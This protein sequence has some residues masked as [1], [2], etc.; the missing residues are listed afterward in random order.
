V[1]RHGDGNYGDSRAGH[2]SGPSPT[3]GPDGPRRPAPS[4][5]GRGIIVHSQLLPGPSHSP[6][7]TSINLFPPSLGFVSATETERGQWQAG[8]AEPSS[9]SAT[10]PSPSAP[11]SSSSLF[12]WLCLLLV[13]LPHHSFISWISLVASASQVPSPFRPSSKQASKSGAVPSE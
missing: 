1:K 6:L 5:S 7:D 10:V 11:R 13:Q 8:S 2:G 12:A 9:I 4:G 3:T